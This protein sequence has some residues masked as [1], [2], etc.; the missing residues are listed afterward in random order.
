MTLRDVIRNTARE[1]FAKEGYQSVSMRRIA[2]EIGCSP[3][4][5]YRHFADKDDLLLSICEETFEQMNRR[6]DQEAQKFPPSLERLRASVGTIMDFHVSHPNHFR[7]TYLTSLPPGP[8]AERKASMARRTVDRLRAGIR[9]CAELKGINIDVEAVTQM[10][11]VAIHG[12]A[13]I[14]INTHPVC[15]LGNPQQLK[16]ELIRTLT[17]QLE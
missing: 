16:Q 1:L 9:E 5:M 6:L 17:A 14:M 10:I 4:A 2:T 12:F 7:V 13:S 8:L 11:R 3:M 15:P